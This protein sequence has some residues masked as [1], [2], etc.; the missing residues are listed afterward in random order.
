MSITKSEGN[1]L[2]KPKQNSGYWEYKLT[3]IKSKVTFSM[4]GEVKVVVE[5]TS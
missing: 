5:T 2:I 1:K 3:E 4:G